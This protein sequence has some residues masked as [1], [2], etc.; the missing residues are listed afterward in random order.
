MVII[1]FSVLNRINLTGVTH[2]SHFPKNCIL[3]IT[4]KCIFRCFFNRRAKSP[5]LLCIDDYY[6]ICFVSFYKNCIFLLLLLLQ[7]WLFFKSNII[8]MR[9]NLI[10]KRLWMILGKN[11]ALNSLTSAQTVSLELYISL[12]Y[13]VFVF[14]FACNQISDNFFFVK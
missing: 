8:F 1:G 12:M 3:R 7:S 14:V 5:K 2:A 13:I 10:Q 9:T 6:T 11:D 4:T